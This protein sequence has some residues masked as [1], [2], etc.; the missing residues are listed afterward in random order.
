MDREAF[1]EQRMI[2][3]ILFTSP[4]APP[5]AA[6]YGYI[7]DPIS[8][9]R[10]GRGRGRGTRRHWL[11]EAKFQHN[12]PEKTVNTPT[13]F[14]IRPVDPERDFKRLV[15]LFNAVNSNQV[16]VSDFEHDYFQTSHPYRLMVAVGP[17]HTAI[18][19]T[20]VICYPGSLAGHFYLQLIVDPA[21]R[22]RG[23]GSQL[24]EDLL[25]FCVSQGITRLSVFVNQDCPDGLRFS[26]NRGFVET[27][28][29][30]EMVLDLL[31]FDEQPYIGII[32][33]LEAKGFFF[34]SLAALGNTLEARRKLFEINNLT[35]LDTPGE[36]E[37]PWQT[38]EQFDE[39]VCSQPWYQPAGQLVAID[40]STGEFAGM[41]AVTVYESSQSAY[42]LH[43]GVYRAYRGQGIALALK[44]MGIRYALSQGAKIIRTHNKPINAPML[45]I[46]HL[47]GYRPK[48]GVYTFEKRFA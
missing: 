3:C 7:Q 15:E 2:A 37:L 19:F 25:A 8:N 48:P 21:C 5:L 35:G 1:G 47:L 13:D 11:K 34:T 31:T 32:P 6:D 43:T 38:F 10:Q 9:R 46:N 4:P 27:N 42:N 45:A 36:T 41:C 12:R 26:A 29:R 44:L 14:H 23:V 28:F 33:R 22:R 18:G 16:S 24:Y 30:V 39:S 20:E 40:E 17:D